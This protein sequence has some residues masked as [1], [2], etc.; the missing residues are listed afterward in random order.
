MEIKAPPI[1]RA[2]AP[3][4]TGLID[5]G[6]IIRGVSANVMPLLMEKRKKRNTTIAHLPNVL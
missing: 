4:P 1:P 3:E 5:D 2:L 6:I